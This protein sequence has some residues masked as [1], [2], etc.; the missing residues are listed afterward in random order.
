M[1]WF[2]LR[3]IFLM[4]RVDVITMSITKTCS[5]LQKLYAIWNT[6]TD[7]CRRPETQAIKYHYIIDSMFKFGK[8]TLYMMRIL[9]FSH[10]IS[11]LQLGL[12]FTQFRQEIESYGAFKSTA[13]KQKAKEI[14]VHIQYLNTNSIQIF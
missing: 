12:Q 13:R 9:Q 8:I 3:Q 2:V 14:S 6:I 7:W 4:L 5:D 11:H 10:A 1:N